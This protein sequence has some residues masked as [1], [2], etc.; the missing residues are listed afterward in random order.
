MPASLGAIIHIFS[1]IHKKLQKR[2]VE[3]L[4]SPAGRGFSQPHGAPEPRFSDA[5]REPLAG[6]RRFI[7]EG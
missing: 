3:V 4:I 2:R 6:R 7:P 1:V 5:D